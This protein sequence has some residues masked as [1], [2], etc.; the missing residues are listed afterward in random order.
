MN[1]A[2]DKTTSVVKRSTADEEGTTT[3]PKDGKATED[4]TGHG[5]GMKV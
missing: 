3:R 2:G 5:S 4:K 1:I